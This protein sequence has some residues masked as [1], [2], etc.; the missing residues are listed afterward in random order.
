MQYSTKMSTF[1]S[2]N[3]GLQIKCPLASQCQIRKF[4]FILTIMQFEISH[5]RMRSTNSWFAFIVVHWA[6]HSCTHTQFFYHIQERLCTVITFEVGNIYSIFDKR[7]IHYFFIV[8]SQ[9]VL[10]TLVRSIYR[11]NKIH[12]F[13]EYIFCVLFEKQKEKKNKANRKHQLLW[14]ATTS[15]E[16][17][18]VCM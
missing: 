18:C 8:E 3:S 7:Q 11:D 13:E 14:M 12:Y 17:V 1:D 10:D 9:F 4:H 2:A 5:E 16:C 15:I 6:L